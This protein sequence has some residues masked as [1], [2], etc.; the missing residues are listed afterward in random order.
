MLKDMPLWT[1]VKKLAGADGKESTE[2]D[3]AIYEQT[4]EFVTP[5]DGDAQI[6]KQLRDNGCDLSKPRH[7]RHFHYLLTDD[8]AQALARDLG[9]K[10]YET[11]AYPSATDHSVWVVLAERTGIVDEREVASE[12]FLMTTLSEKYNAEYDGWE[13]AGAD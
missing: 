12:R 3:E 7:V 6:L 2:I 5:E 11:T 4:G 13:A 8:E 9:E 1:R 10:G